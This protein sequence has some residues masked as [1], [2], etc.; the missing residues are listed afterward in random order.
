MLN[1]GGI[2]GQF[3]TLTLRFADIVGN[4]FDFIINLKRPGIQQVRDYT[5]EI[6]SR[7][8]QSLLSG[9]ILP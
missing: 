1:N 4:G 5:T 9:E 3:N 2:Y 7:N 8:I 6:F